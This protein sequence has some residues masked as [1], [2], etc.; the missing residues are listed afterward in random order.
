MAVVNSS[1]LSP[2]SIWPNILYYRDL[3]LRA[4]WSIL[5][6]TL[7]FAL[8]GLGTAATTTNVYEA[9][10]VVALAEHSVRGAGIPSGA[11]RRLGH[12]LGNLGFST[13]LAAGLSGG[14]PDQQIFPIMKSRDFLTRFVER[15]QSRRKLDS[16]ASDSDASD[17][18]ASNPDEARD[19][20]AFQSTVAKLQDTYRKFRGRL[21]TMVEE[22]MLK[23]YK[24]TDFDQEPRRDSASDLQD[25]YRKF[26]RAIAIERKPRQALT[27]VKF[28][29]KDPV[30]AAEWANALVAEIN[31]TLRETT[32][33]ESRQRIAYL[34]REL[35]KTSVIPLRQSIYRLIEAEFHRIMIAETRL[36]YALKVIDRAVPPH[37]N[38]PIRPRRSHMIWTTALMG[39]GIGAFWA[40]WRDS[41]RML[42]GLVEGS[43]AAR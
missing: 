8:V 27:H 40:I 29:W 38:D 34:N 30:A 39:F 25:R 36:D 15:H 19:V 13:S 3:F 16:D 12:Q 10:V 1:F 18:D 37:P 42:R 41:I 17:S 11:L 2:D 5:V 9:T 24:P 20:P 6:W 43:R 31:S 7:T 35:E 4:K 14:T 26:R 28:R 32:I 21:S 33:T 22:L 23:L